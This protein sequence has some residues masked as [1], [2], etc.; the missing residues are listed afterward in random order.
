MMVGELP[1][2][3]SYPGD[4]SVASLVQFEGGKAAWK[5]S[6]NLFLYHNYFSLLLQ[7]NVMVECVTEVTQRLDR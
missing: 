1:V 3:L 4:A 2:G 6:L 5:R 7:N